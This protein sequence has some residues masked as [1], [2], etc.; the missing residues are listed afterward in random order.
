MSAR[1]AL[2]GLDIS[3]VLAAFLEQSQKHGHTADSDADL[4]LAFFRN[5]LISRAQM[6]D[7]ILPG[8]RQRL[9]VGYS[10]AATIAAFAL[11]TMRRI[12]REQATCNT[13]PA[14]CAHPHT[15]RVPPSR[16]FPFG[17]ERCHDCKA[18]LVRPQELGR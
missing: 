3:A 5:E 4:S 7:V 1:S 6:L 11:A 13:A 16:D 17:A 8:D 2:E 9:D 18:V 15:L 12:R 14:A 10:R